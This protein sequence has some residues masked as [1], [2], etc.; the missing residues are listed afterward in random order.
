MEQISP[1]SI[2]AP[3]DIH[4][5]LCL[6][7]FSLFRFLYKWLWLFNIYITLLLEAVF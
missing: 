1:I 4:S 5:T 3:A 2:L 6:Y 7:K